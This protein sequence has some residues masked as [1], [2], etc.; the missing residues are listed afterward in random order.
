MFV[1]LL[2]ALGACC[3]WGLIFVVPQYLE[4]YSAVEIVLGRYFSYG[5]LSALVFFRTGFA[6]V[7]RYPLKVWGTVGV[8]ALVSN[9]IYYLGLVAGLRFASPTLA[10]L[11][12]GMAPIVIALY[13]NWQAREVAFRDLIQPCIWIGFGLILVNATEVDWSFKAKSLGHYLFGLSGI[14][15]ALLGWSA[16]AVHNARFLKRNPTIGASEWSTIMGVAT[17]FWVLLIGGICAI[18]TKDEV[19]IAKFL[20]LSSDTIRYFTGA[21]L[22]GIA[23]SWLG[24]FLWSQAS[25][26]LP[27]FLLGPLLVFETFFGLLFVF[28]FQKQLPSW[29]EL[30]G[31]CAMLGGIIM[32]VNAFRKKQLPER[33]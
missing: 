33:P 30:A 32:S 7:R 21:A 2:F 25:L 3:V 11:I 13:G 23:C 19:N 1:G 20:V 22:L 5:L 14:V 29:I 12:I 17:L 31:V 15:V 4:D 26:Y 16:C 10:V 8:F 18:G 6:R 9:L 27:I 28:L 24:C